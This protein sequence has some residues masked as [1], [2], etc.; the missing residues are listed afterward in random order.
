MV[1]LAPQLTRKAQQAYAAMKRE[2]VGRYEKEAILRRYNIS[3][4]TSAAI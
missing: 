4:E 2:D 3:E 1:K